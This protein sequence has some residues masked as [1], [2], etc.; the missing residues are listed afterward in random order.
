MPPFRDRRFAFVP[1]TGTVMP[2][3]QD[4]SL[5]LD[6]IALL[7]QLVA[8]DSV[9]PDLVPGAAGE[10]RIAEFC[11]DWLA[12]HGFEVVR[13]EGVKGRPSVVGIRRGGGGGRSLL[14]L[15]HTDTVSL[16]GYDGDPLAPIARDG[17]IYGRGAYD[18]KSGLAAIMVAAARAARAGLAG[19]V[20]VAAVA[21][22]EFGSIGTEEVVGRFSADA[23]IVTE[24][25]EL[26]LTLAHRGFAWFEL[27]LTGRAAH[28]SM[29]ERGVD[30]I[31]HAGLV[32]DALDRLRRALQ[33]RPAHPL[34]GR[35]AVRV[36]KI[37]GGEDAATVAAR[38]RLTIERRMV[39]GE[40]PAVIEAEL[41]GLL[42]G[43]AAS[44]PD[45]RYSLERL[46]ARSAFEADGAWPIVT[47][48]TRR[49]EEVLGRAPR[50]RGEPF[51]TDAGLIADAGIPCLLF[52][53]AGGG[54]HA[55]T[56]WVD[57]AS[58]RQVI[59]VLTA[60]IGDF[61]GGAT[62]SAQGTASGTRG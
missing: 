4:S 22:E 11:G 45:F 55:A 30:A 44:V 1:V 6:P 35:G 48:L 15:G 41:R 61:C 16:A 8:I 56:E 60:T 17:R 34:L 24:P 50:V 53:V 12:S 3:P 14:L 43:L 42:D 47:T 28:G 51:W 2:A 10:S 32:L 54:A 21:D 29:P 38:C 57:L 62:G 33:D 25:T 40:T 20:L 13:L 49:A 39:P 26:E 9:N 46:V 59:D 36:A 5:E 27:E 52:G 23:A 31:L 18:M 7:Q 19:D 58:L 37:H